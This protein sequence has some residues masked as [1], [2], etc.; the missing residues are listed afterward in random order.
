MY[1][2]WTESLRNW[3]AGFVSW[4]GDFITE[5]T[6][7]QGQVSSAAATAVIA[8][9]KALASAH[10]KGVWSALSGPLIAPASVSHDGVI[11][12]LNADVPDVTAVVPGVSSV[13]T[14]SLADAVLQTKTLGNVDL[15]IAITSGFYSFGTPTNGPA[16]VADSQ[17]IVSRG[18]DTATQIIVDKATGAVFVRG[19]SDLTSAPAWSAW[20]RVAMHN[21][22]VVP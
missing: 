13:W 12:L 11:W 16:G 5:V 9:D 17:L 18:G 1:L 10:F 22:V 14:S 21:E 8:A 3:L 7:V 2:T 6:A 19:A 20:R 4:I 15:N